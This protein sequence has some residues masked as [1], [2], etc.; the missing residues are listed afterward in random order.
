M[1]CEGLIVDKHISIAHLLGTFKTFAQALFDKKAIEMRIR[2]S[3][4]PFVEPGLEID[5]S[6]PFCT[7]GCA[8]CKKT[9]WL[10]LAGAGLIHPHVL[11]ACSI[12]PDEYQGFAWGFGIDRLAM[13]TYGI[14]DIRLLR[15]NKIEFLKQF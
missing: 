11:R 12:D 1:Q 13:L 2:P 8:I 3:Y 9:K 5:I 6:C 7:N 15:S 14:N 10:E 4:F